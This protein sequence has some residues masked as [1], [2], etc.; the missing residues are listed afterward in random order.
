MENDWRKAAFHFAE[1]KAYR[2]ENLDLLTALE[3]LCLSI[4]TDY[5]L[6]VLYWSM[7]HHDLRIFQVKLDYPRHLSSQCLLISPRFDENSVE[8]RS[9]SLPPLWR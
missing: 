3:N 9:A 8:F 6:N 2:P 4:A 7:S 1:A 5:R